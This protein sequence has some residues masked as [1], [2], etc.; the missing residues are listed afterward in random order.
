M[1]T[2]FQNAADAID[3]VQVRGCPCWAPYDE[4]RGPAFA[5]SI[6]QKNDV[7]RA[8]ARLEEFLMLMCPMVS[9]GD[10]QLLVQHH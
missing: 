7:R 6:L 4:G 3:V 8:R 2:L 1:R 10:D 9:I 5:L